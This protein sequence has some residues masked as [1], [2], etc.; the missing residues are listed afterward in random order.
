MPHFKYKI[1]DRHGRPT[2]GI[3]ESDSKEAVAGH[4]KKMGYAPI[5]IEEAKS[6]FTRTGLFFENFFLGKVKLEEIIVFTRQLMVLQRAGVPILS[7][8]TS[9][10]EQVYN[11][12]F[13]KVIE[14]I[15][16]SIESGKSLS[17]SLAQ[18]PDIFSETYVNMVRSG[19]VAGVLDDVLKRL[20]DLLE[21]ELDIRMKVKQATRYPLLVLIAISIAF[22][23]AV[24]FIIPKFADLFRTFD[25]PLPIPTRMLIG[26]NFILT[27]YWFLVILSIGFFIVLLKRLISRERFRP[28]LDRFKLK[29]PVFG[30]LYLKITMSRFIKMTSVMISSGI[31]IINTLETVKG[32]VG[33]KIVA[34]SVDDII[35]GI[36]EGESMALSMKTS[37]LYP[38]IVTQMVKVGEDTG[39]LDELLMCVAEYYDAQIDYIVKNLAVLVEPMLI[40]VLGV[41][42]LFLALGIFL[43]MWNLASLYIKV[44]GLG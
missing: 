9:I 30:A 36:T 20:G 13:K 44:G 2:T 1:R 27:H 23:V 18:Y 28:Y 24:M 26:L 3:I 12:Y 29:A 38:S 14:K 6:G 37:G 31:P 7:S 10:Y 34:G 42:V 39:K 22:P 41:M 5:L 16:H 8:L 4:F 21:H 43:P 25:T 33:N 35:A 11:R 40:F 19:E 15:L 32:S 17:E